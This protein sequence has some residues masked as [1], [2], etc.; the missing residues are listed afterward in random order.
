VAGEEN[1]AA[2]PATSPAAATEETAP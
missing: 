1:E 2:A